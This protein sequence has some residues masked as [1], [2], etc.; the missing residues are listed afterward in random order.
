MKKF[1]I[2]LAVLAMIAVGASIFLFIET[3]RQSKKLS[4]VIPEAEA[5]LTNWKEQNN[6]F[7]EPLPCTEYSKQ[8][9]EWISQ[10]ELYKAKKEQTPIFQGYMFLRDF[11]DEY[12]PDFNLG[13]M[14]SLAAA[15]G[16][17]LMFAF[18]MVH[19]SGSKKKVE[20]KYT[21]R[22]EMPKRTEQV[23]HQT[24]STAALPAARAV[25]DSD[26]ALLRKA[27]EC[28]ESEPMQAI[29][30]L[31]QAIEGSLGAKLSVPALLLCGSLRLKNKIGEEQ[32]RK[33]LEKILYLSPQS[34]EAKKA[35]TVLDMFQ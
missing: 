28:A 29:S 26:Q 27:T 3:E 15:C 24:A 2:F 19:F 5:A 6:C 7:E 31:E 33:Q 11:D 25:P 12:V 4:K 32:G 30:Y 13:G 1:C 17:L 21:R 16:L 8:V 18:L 23:R 34:P 10:F 35:Q 9:E 20:P 14:A 22:N